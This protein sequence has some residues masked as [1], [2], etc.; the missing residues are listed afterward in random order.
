MTLSKGDNM[1]KKRVLLIDDERDLVDMV[2]IRLESNGY[3]VLPA[4]DGVEGLKIA[5]EKKPDIILLD[6]MM[7]KKDG[8]TVL[9]ELRADEKLRKVPVIVITAK[10]QLKDLFE[11]EGVKYYILKPI[12]NKELLSRIAE[13]VKG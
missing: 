4:Y 5:K 11:I 3:D 6:I 12:D 9:K 13:V 7:P 1:D 10:P 8:Y 2:K